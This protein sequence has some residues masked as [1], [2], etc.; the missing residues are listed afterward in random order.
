MNYI[1]QMNTIDYVGDA[2]GLFSSYLQKVPHISD[3]LWFYYEV[4][5]YNMVGI[6]ES[7]RTQ[8]STL[9]I[10]DAQRNIIRSLQSSDNSEMLDQCLPILRS[11]ICK[12]SAGFASRLTLFG[13][14]PSQLIFYLVNKIY[15]AGTT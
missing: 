11:Y 14:A 15:S 13:V 4:V 3:L 9:T 12:D 7:F 10:S 1:F 6:P 2:L 8:I 5:V